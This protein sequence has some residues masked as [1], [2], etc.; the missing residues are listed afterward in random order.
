MTNKI[1]TAQTQAELELIAHQQIQAKIVAGDI[2]QAEKEYFSNTAYGR[3]ILNGTAVEDTD[4]MAL[5][6]AKIKEF[7]QLWE[8]RKGRPERAY[9]P[10][11]WFRDAVQAAQE[12]DPKYAGGAG[13]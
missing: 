6:V 2:K 1:T 11:C 13:F 12:S 9:Q 5:L 10:M 8:G 3:K 4:H 7:M